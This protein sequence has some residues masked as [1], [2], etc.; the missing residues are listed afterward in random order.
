MI[1]EEKDYASAL[2]VELPETETAAETVADDAGTGNVDDSTNNGAGIN[3]E[4]NGG[5]DNGSDTGDDTAIDPNASAAA[6]RRAMESRIERER[7]R[8]RQEERARMIAEIR[9][10]NA[11]KAQTPAPPAV[12]AQNQQPPRDGAGRFARRNQQQTQ[13]PGA[14]G[15]DLSRRVGE[16]I[17]K[18]PAVIAA[19][20]YTEQMHENEVRAAFSADLAKITEMDPSIKTEEDLLALPE[21]DLILGLVSKGYSPSDAYRT[22]F[23][24]KITAA[25][26]ER[27]R[28]QAE[29]KVQSVSHQIPDKHRGTGGDPGVQV[30]A[31]VRQ[32]YRDMMPGISDA[33]IVKHYAKYRK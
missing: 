28:R 6:R 29:A 17:D 25:A 18:H 19:K 5:D 23:F 7:E 11:A 1:L 30:P 13:T 10:A 16:I 33:D 8:A 31:D 4:E 14:G 20:Q 24:D 32:M 3:A 21:H 22:V 9:R 12:P 26:V 27:G 15:D 2:G